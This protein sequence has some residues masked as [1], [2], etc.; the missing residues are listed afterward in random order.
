MIVFSSRDSR[1]LS[2]AYVVAA[3]EGVEAA[4]IDAGAPMGPLL[5]KVERYGLRPSHLFVTHR[6]GDHTTH[7]AEWVRRFRCRVVAHSLEAGNIP[8]AVETVEDRDTVIVGGVAVRVLHVPGHTTG[9][10]AFLVGGVAVFSGDTLFRGSVGGTVGPGHATFADLR[11]S[12]LD[13]LLALPGEVVIH[14]G[15]MEATTVAEELASNPFVRAWRGRDATEEQP[16]EALG[17]PATLLLRARDY[18]GGTKCWV[19]FDGGEEAVVPGSRVN[20]LSR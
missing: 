14:P 9:H 10:A 20:D 15:H 6:H 11:R 5:E 17:R 3:A 8:H 13:V 1:F 16:C 19:R 4:V 2:N 12:V 7:L 18:D